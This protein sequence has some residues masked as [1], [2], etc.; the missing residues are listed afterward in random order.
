MTVSSLHIQ[1]YLFPEEVEYLCRFLKCRVSTDQLWDCC[2]KLND[3]K[4]NILQFKA[5]Y[6]NSVK[7]EHN[8]T[9]PQHFQQLGGLELSS[10]HVDFRYK[11][12]CCIIFKSIKVAQSGKKIQPYL[13]NVCCIFLRSHRIQPHVYIKQS[14]CGV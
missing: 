12:Y 2:C 14:P 3:R 5:I 6:N 10:G 4:M 9:N 13:S 11:L 7:F 1:S 8:Q